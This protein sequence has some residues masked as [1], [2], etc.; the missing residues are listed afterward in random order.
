MAISG[1]VITLA[2]NPAGAAALSALASDLRLTLGERFGQ[3]VALV[4]ETPSARNDHD[5]FDQL[6]ELPGITQVDVTY[7]H[8]DT[9]PGYCDHAPHS[10]SVEDLHAHH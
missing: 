4:A 2:E 3:R 9:N 6:R 1:L 5:L 8:L 7:V 10:Q